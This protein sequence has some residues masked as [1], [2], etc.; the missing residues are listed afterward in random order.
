VVCCCGSWGKR[1]QQ[2]E[3]PA[4]FK[5]IAMLVVVVIAMLVVVAVA[6]LVVVVLVQSLVCP[7][8]VNVIAG[9]GGNR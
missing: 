5:V 7:R 1:R 8:F 4:W 6:I 2:R 3:A 9:T